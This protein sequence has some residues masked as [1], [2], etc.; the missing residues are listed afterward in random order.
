MLSGPVT[1]YINIRWI[2]I[3]YVTSGLHYKFY[4]SFTFPSGIAVYS[5]L[6]LRFKLQLNVNI[7]DFILPLAIVWRSF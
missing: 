3:R 4:Y 6:L 5:C 2:L 7:E 1:V